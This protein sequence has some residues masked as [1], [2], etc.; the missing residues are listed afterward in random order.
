MSSRWR[1]THYHFHQSFSNGVSPPQ[2]AA[3]AYEAR[4]EHEGFSKPGYVSEATFQVWQAA[5]RHDEPPTST[6]EHA[7]MTMSQKCGLSEPA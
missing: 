1:L 5:Q 7:Q 6:A 3:P 4:P 2:D